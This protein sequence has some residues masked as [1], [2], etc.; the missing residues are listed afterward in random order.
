VAIG[1]YYPSYYVATY[2]EPV[3]VSYADVARV[4]APAVAVEVG[5]QPQPASGYRYDGGPARPVPLPAT[6]R[7]PPAPATFDAVARRP[8]SR[9]EYPAYGETPGRLRG[10][11]V[12]DPLL[13]K[14]TLGK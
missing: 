12:V 6:P 14:N 4:S 8:V 1:G 7:T 13:V 9:L 2:S 3:V 5:P 10:T 11:K